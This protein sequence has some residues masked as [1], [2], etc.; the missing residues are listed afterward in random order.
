MIA[1]QHTAQQ[2]NLAVLDLSHSNLTQM[3]FQSLA[4]TIHTAYY[5]LIRQ[6]TSVLLRKKR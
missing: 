3:D 6:T 2:Y 1:Y 4:P 5:T